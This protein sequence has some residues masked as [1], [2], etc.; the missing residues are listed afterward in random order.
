MTIRFCC[1]FGEIKIDL[2]LLKSN[3]NGTIHTY[4]IKFMPRMDNLNG[5][6]ELLVHFREST[7]RPDSRNW[8]SGV[9][10]V[11]MVTLIV[12]WFELYP[13]WIQLKLVIY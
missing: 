3:S 11:Q 12:V 13:D 2:T 10:T 4:P 7:L 1:S 6:S 5:R 9:P 8:P